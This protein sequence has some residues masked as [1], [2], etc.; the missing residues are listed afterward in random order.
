MWNEKCCQKCK[1]MFESKYF[2]NC[3]KRGIELDNLNA[4]CRDFKENNGGDLNIV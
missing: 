1:Y 4:Y 2:K 3:F